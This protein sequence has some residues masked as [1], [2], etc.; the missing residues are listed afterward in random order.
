[1]TQICSLY[2]RGLGHI[3]GRVKV[4]ITWYCK[5]Q[6]I[7]PDNLSFAKKFVIDGLVAAGVIDNDGWKNILGF[8]DRFEVDKV[9]PRVEIMLIGE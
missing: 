4:G 5:N 2:A 1:M 8:E 6:K 9:N 3:D 7:D